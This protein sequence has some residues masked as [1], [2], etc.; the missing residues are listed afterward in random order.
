M[1]LNYFIDV[2]FDLVNECDMLELVDLWVEEQKL[3][4]RLSDGTSVRIVCERL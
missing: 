4:I 2:L 1:E 3:Y